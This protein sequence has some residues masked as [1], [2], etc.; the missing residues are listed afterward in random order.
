MKYKDF[1]VMVH[2]PLP[3]IVSVIGGTTVL[4]EYPPK[5]PIQ[6]NTISTY[7]A[8]QAGTHFWIIATNRSENDASVIFYV[9]GQMAACLLCYK[10]NHSVNCRGVQ[11]E[12]GLLRKFRFR[13]VTLTGITPQTAISNG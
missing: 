4:T 6:G 2:A 10:N 5:D 1:E 9:D 8:S 12:A 7:I 3:G 11:P 13:K